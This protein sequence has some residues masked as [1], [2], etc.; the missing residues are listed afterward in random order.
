MKES[1][2]YERDGLMD[3]NFI[4]Q[5]FINNGI[6]TIDDVMNSENKEGLMTTIID[7]IHRYTITHTNDGRYTTY[8]TDMTKPNGRRQVRRKS[9]TE[10]YNYL[11]EF[12]GVS[13]NLKDI[14]FAELYDE[15]ISYKRRYVDVPNRKRSISPSTIRRYERDFE[16]YMQDTEWDISRKHFPMRNVVSIYTAKGR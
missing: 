9:K 10:L 5:N 8:V 4:F 16:K 13:G 6:I 1:T 3:Y 14:T 11:L 12:Y 7:T 2:L 15:W